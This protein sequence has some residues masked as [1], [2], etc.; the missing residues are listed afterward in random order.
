MSE[1]SQTG[2]RRVIAGAAVA[3]T[4]ALAGCLDTLVGDGSEDPDSL[5]EVG[6]IVNIPQEEFLAIQE[7]LQ[8]EIEDGELDEEDF[9]IEFQRRQ[10][11]LIESETEALKSW[12]ESES[13][14]TV[15]D[16]ILDIGGMTISAAADRCIDVLGDDQVGGLLPAEEIQE[17]EQTAP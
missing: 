12:L 1:T 15:E 2:R 11:D 6:V 5:R 14:I 17:P 13:G 10:Q 7:E 16:A 3:G 8:Q 4:A 9:Q